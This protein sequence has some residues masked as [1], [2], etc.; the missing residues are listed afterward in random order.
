MK[1][2]R[3]I[4]G[5]WLDSKLYYEI[6]GST[7][8]NPLDGY[9]GGL[10]GEILV[11]TIHPDYEGYTIPEILDRIRWNLANW[12]VSKCWKEDTSLDWGIPLGYW[13]PPIAEKI[14]SKLTKLVIK[15]L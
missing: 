14:H 1:N 13:K 12:V 3:Y 2:I 8:W 6:E 10:L 9:R 4:V 11:T 15:G 5:D 7:P